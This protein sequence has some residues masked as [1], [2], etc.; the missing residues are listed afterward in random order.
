MSYQ[1]LHKENFGA[2]QAII[3]AIIA[4]SFFSFADAMG[5]WLQAEGFDKHFILVV[6]QIPSLIIMFSYLMWKQGWTKTFLTGHFKWHVLRA[7]SIVS[8]TYFLFLAVE[9]LPLTDLY[10]VVFCS[11]FITAIGAYLFFRERQTKSEWIVIATGFIGVL[12]VAQPDYGG[13]DIAY[14]YAFCQ[15]LSV[16]AASLLIRKIGPHEHPFTF[17]VYA[18]V[19][20]ILAN[21]YPATQVS[22]PDITMM[23]S[24]V[25]AGYAFV[26]PLAILSLS[27]AFAHTPRMSIVLPFIYIQIIWGTILGYLIF[28]DMLTWNVTIGVGIIILCGLY[29]I[30]HKPNKKT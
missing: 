16:S 27:M 13:F 11:P 23:H 6:T 17:V 28:D 22:M 9:R 30:F 29:L 15:A 8:L 19:A 10:G 25:F 21:F 20:V 5:K 7:L 18:N 12:F 4:Y 1:L 26:L 14:I 3:L 24:Y 2:L